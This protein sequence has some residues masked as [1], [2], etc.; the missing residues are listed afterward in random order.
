M[1]YTSFVEKD[2]VPDF[3]IRR[4][5]RKLL[6]QRLQDENKGS[7]EANQTQLMKLIAGLKTESIAIETAAANEQHYEVPTAFYQF[8]LGKHLK[9]SSG[10]WKEGVTD[11]DT[12]E[13]DMLELTCERAELQ[14][15]QDVLELGCGWGS[16]SLF[17]SARYPGSRFTVVSN[18]AT[19]K[20]HIDAQAKQRGLQNLQV[21]T[22]DINVFAS[23]LRFDRV[24]SVEMF[25][26]MRNYELLM[27]KVAHHL[28]P[29]GKLFVHIFTHKD[30]AYRFEVIDESDWMSKYF[31]TGGI[32]PSDHLLLY[33]NKQ[34]SIEQH[35]RLSGMHYSKTSEAWLSNMDKH[36]S[37]ILPLFEATYGKD[38][39]LKWWVYWR[40]FYMS[41]AE[42]W[43]YNKGEEWIVSH[44][45]FKKK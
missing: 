14:N 13:Q 45:L 24:V 34:F 43:G 11:I 15:G 23:E 38:Q 31:F 2:Q 4:Q 17:M 44:Y 10:F 16:L 19:Q 9:Y 27:A 22:A 30:L 1:W 5:I 40:I 7:I 35:W 8:C 39:A 33:F 41:C 3:L 28:K 29:E 26:H 42:L 36:K 20:Q 12:S 37:D 32:M 25:E 18:S 21:I 6:A